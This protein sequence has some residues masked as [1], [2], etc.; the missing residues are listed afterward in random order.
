MAV[1][2][3]SICFGYYDSKSIHMFHLINNSKQFNFHIN[4]KQFVP[5]DIIVLQQFSTEV[6][7]RSIW[8]RSQRVLSDSGKRMKRI[9]D[10]VCYILW[11][12]VL[13]P[14]CA[15]CY[16][17]MVQKFLV[18]I[19]AFEEHRQAPVQMHDW[20]YKIYANNKKNEASAWSL[21]KSKLLYI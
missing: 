15:V 16:I 9:C 5:G 14:Y 6:F 21:H 10:I 1:Y 7:D 18:R 11:W 17:I 8:S 20:C 13:M 4:S 19:L 3:Q 2:H 12:L